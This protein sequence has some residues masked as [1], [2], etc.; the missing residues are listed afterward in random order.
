MANATPLCQRSSAIS[1]S[2]DSAIA[3]MS[4]GS[5]LRVKS[6][7]LPALSRPTLIPRKQASSTMLLKKVRNTTVAP[8]QR[9]AASSRNRIR[10]ATRNSSACGR[11]ALIG[12]AFHGE[13]LRA[14]A[15]HAAGQVGDLLEAGLGEH[16]GRLG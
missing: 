16:V 6:R 3:S 9:I 14:P 11:R 13:A 5:E 1:V 7:P 2:S 15:Q 10:K 8:N 4:S 12:T